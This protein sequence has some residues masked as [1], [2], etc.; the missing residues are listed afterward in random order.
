MFRGK[1]KG[2]FTGSV[3]CSGSGT[4]A[5]ALSEIFHENSRYTRAGSA[6]QLLHIAKHM[7]S[8]LAIEALS[9]NF[10]VFRFAERCALP[11]A[12]LPDLSLSQALRRRVSTRQFS[13]ATLSL[14][15]LSAV[16]VPAVACTRRAV[17]AD[18]PGVTL[19]FRPYPSGGGEYPVE[20]YLILL[21]VEGRPL[22]VVH[23]DPLGCTLDVV[24]GH[25]S[26]E[27][28]A[29]SLMQPGDA[30]Q[31]AAALIVLTAIFERSTAKYGDRGYRF[32]LLEAGHVAQNLCLTA[33]A[34]G[35]G[36][37]AWGGFYDDDLNHLL[38]VD[39][40]HEAAVHCLLLGGVV[41]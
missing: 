39:G 36:S 27:T 11:S 20:I 3:V 41:S 15:T 19:H 6:R 22:Q 25:V 26:F 13:G 23:F 9:H 5:V 18:F 10:K 2:S 4:Q 16:L 33:A 7:R 32:A 31:T 37:L 28:V 38:K 14:E 35:V 12:S 30:L 29:R 21:R 1:S 34:A 8:A 40:T 24:V 17:S